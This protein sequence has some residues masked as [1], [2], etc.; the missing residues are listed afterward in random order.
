[1]TCTIHVANI[2]LSLV[3]AR[4][5]IVSEVYNLIQSVMSMYM[6]FQLGDEIYIVSE[7]TVMLHK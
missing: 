6:H 2:L 7:T 4:S 5:I 3:H 1:M